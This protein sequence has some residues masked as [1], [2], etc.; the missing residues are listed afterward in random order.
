MSLLRLRASRVERTGVASPE[1]HPVGCPAIWLIASLP[2]LAV[3]HS[4]V[5]PPA[6][7][8][9]PAG[10]WRVGRRKARGANVVVARTAPGQQLIAKDERIEVVKQDEFVI[11]ERPI[12]RLG[13]QQ[14][15]LP[16]GRAEVAR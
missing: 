12:E 15:S 16:L 11:E 7:R 2:T 4:I 1:C 6:G 3:W 8:V 9:G 5:V 13:E 10:G 14:A